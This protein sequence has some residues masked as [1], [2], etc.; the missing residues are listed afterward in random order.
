MKKVIVLLFIGLF[1]MGCENDISEEYRDD[2]QLETR[3]T[4]PD[5]PPKAKKDK[6][7]ICHMGQ[8]IYVPEKTLALHLAHGDLI[9]PCQTCEYGIEE[10]DL[11]CE[12]LEGI[13]N[14][15]PPDNNYRCL[16]NYEYGWVRYSI[17]EPGN[18]FAVGG[19][20]TE[21]GILRLYYAS[22][23]NQPFEFY[24]LPGESGYAEAESL[25]NFI[26]YKVISVKGYDCSSNVSCEP[27]PWTYP[28]EFTFF[29]LCDFLDNV[30]LEK[31][32]CYSRNTTYG[33]LSDIIIIG[34]YAS[35]DMKLQLYQYNDDVS[36]HDAGV[37]LDPD[38]SSYL[39]LKFNEGSVEHTYILDM[40]NYIRHKAWTDQW[41]NSYDNCGASWVTSCCEPIQ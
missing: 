1:I 5:L 30:I 9:G 13:L 34:N 39:N 35:M 21:S 16:R 27:E 32:I 17:A 40:M 29:N 33:S 12:Q 4:L 31:F 20:K 10:L 28:S 19:L 14:S 8:S 23:I 24:V 26:K 25:F 15:N 38:G 3:A 22:N 2:I 18:Q 6:V 7:L 11:L 37:V 36:D 41:T